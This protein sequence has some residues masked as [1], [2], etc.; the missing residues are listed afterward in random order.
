MEEGLS[1]ESLVYDSEDLNAEKRVEEEENIKDIVSLEHK[2]DLLL[3]YLQSLLVWNLKYHL[4]V[5]MVLIYF[6]IDIIWLIS[7]RVNIL[8]VFFIVFGLSS[9]FSQLL[10]IFANVGRAILYPADAR[11][12]KKKYRL[13]EAVPLMNQAQLRDFFLR[14][15]S[16]KNRLEERLSAVFN[17]HPTVFLMNTAIILFLFYSLGSLLFSSKIQL[18]FGIYLM[19]VVPGFVY[20][21][22]LGIDIENNKM[23]SKMSSFFTR[24]SIK[25]YGPE[26]KRIPFEKDFI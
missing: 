9:I 26:R 12:R 15:N 25:L 13:S 23:L 16:G 6:A 4:I 5:W 17:L 10:G 11:Q 3:D 14:F 24:I 7:L 19:L 18:L 1:E 2:D 22:Y 20:R 8:A 21:K